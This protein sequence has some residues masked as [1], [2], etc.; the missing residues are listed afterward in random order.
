MKRL[1]HIFCSGGVILSLLILVTSILFWIRGYFVSDRFFWQGYDDIGDRSYWTQNLITTGRGGVGMNRVIQSSDINA[2][3]GPKARQRPG[4]IKHYWSPFYSTKLAEYPYFRMGSG[5]KPV[6][7][8]FKHS[9]FTEPDPAHDRPKRLSWQ[10]V[11]PFWAICALTAPWPLISVWRCRRRRRF[12]AGCCQVCGY[13]LRATPDR[14]PECGSV[15]TKK[16]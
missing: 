15:A 14:C 3:Y 6:W 2:N 1:I 12:V 9:V 7:G 11:V 5:D 13:D 10:V 8:G 4:F 16:G